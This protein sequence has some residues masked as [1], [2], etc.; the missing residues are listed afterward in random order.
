MKE[1]FIV[2]TRTRQVLVC[3]TA[4]VAMVGCMGAH[5]GPQPRALASNAVPQAAVVLPEA[6]IAPVA[7]PS[8][9]QDALGKGAARWRQDVVTNSSLW[10]QR[11]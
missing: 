4:S 5:Y 7:G 2:N 1:F 11:K 3:L 8:V 10:S 9:A 6:P